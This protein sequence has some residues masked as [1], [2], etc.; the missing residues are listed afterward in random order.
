MNL[1]LG[2]QREGL[3]KNPSNCPQGQV[4][5]DAKR[6]LNPQHPSSPFSHLLDVLRVQGWVLHAETQK[7][8][9]G[10]MR[11]LTFRVILMNEYVFG[12]II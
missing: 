5:P 10:L 1:K 2:F 6:K 11:N 9:I 8:R 7:G 3:G 12:A 4:A